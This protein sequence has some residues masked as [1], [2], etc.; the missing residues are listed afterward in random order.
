MST[1]KTDC[2]HELDVV[3]LRTE[4]EGYGLGGERVRVKAGARGAV[5]AEESGSA[6]V[7]VEFI[8]ADTGDPRAFVEVERSALV[9]VRSLR[10]PAA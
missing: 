6:F 5:V 8:D 10:T 3:E 1:T 4:A 9:L 7:E 2:I